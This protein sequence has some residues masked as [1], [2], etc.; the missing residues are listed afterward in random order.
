M[1]QKTFGTLA[2]KN[3]IITKAEVV[4]LLRN[5]PD[6]LSKMAKHHDL[7]MNSDTLITKLT[8]VVRN[9]KRSVV[10]VVI[11]CITVFLQPLWLII[12]F[13]SLYNCEYHVQPTC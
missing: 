12:L 2:K 11:V 10:F 3:P 7:P 1:L 9:L 13:Y 8:D 5:N 6:V 4:S